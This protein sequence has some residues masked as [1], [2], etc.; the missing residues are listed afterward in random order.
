MQTPM[1]ATILSQ[2]GTTQ[3]VIAAMLGD[4]RL[5]AAIEATAAACIKA[6]KAGNKAGKK[7]VHL[8]PV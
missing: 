6:L 7:S 4:A 1:R 3:G 8:S 5:I 2:L